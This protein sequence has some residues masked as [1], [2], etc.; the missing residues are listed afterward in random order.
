MLLF[1]I[2]IACVFACHPE[3]R[4]ACDDPCGEW[5]CS[6]PICRP[7]CE[8][9]C[10]P[11]NCVCYNAATDH[12]YPKVCYIF[13]PEDQ[14]ESDSCPQCEIKCP[15][16]CAYQYE[17]LCQAPDCGWT[18]RT[19]YSCPEPQCEQASTTVTN[20]EPPRCELVSEM[21]ACERNS[22]TKG[23]LFKNFFY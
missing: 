16:S 9:N 7:I 13:C 17:P 8:P 6:D 19:N 12:S 18:C 5:I 11:V 21:P 15:D 23:N 10:K 1:I 2:L 4:W 20:C 22:A 3:S 14:C